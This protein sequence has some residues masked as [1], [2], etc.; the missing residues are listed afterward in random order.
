MVGNWGTATAGYKGTATAG[1]Y[2]TA[3]AGYGGK[4]TT[5]DGGTATAG[6]GGTATAGEKGRLSI[7]YYDNKADRYR[8]VIG[9]VGECGVEANVAYKL[10]SNTRKFVKA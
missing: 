6:D 4:A 2:G 1:D 7:L 9:Y 10:D 3:T 5:G 8:E